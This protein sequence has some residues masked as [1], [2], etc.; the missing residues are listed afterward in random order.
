MQ[1]REILDNMEEI[2]DDRYSRALK[3]FHGDSS[4]RKVFVH[5]ADKRRKGFILNL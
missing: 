2:D 4:W 3:L 5:M 1:C